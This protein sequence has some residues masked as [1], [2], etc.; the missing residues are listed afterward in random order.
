MQSIHFEE[1]HMH[2]T[3]HF[4]KAQEATVA[5]FFETTA[6]AAVS[7]MTLTIPSTNMMMDVDNV[8]APAS[9]SA[10]TISDCSSSSPSTPTRKKNVS[11]VPYVDVYHTFHPEDYGKKTTTIFYLSKKTVLTHHTPLLFLSRSILYFS[12]SINSR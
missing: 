12:G 2:S 4:T 10:S 5:A 9:P 6:S 3:A 1:S 8:P 7:P 11:F